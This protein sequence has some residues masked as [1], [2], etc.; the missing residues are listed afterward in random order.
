MY[1]FTL[2]IG[3]DTYGSVQEFACGR[4]PTFHGYS[5][6]KNGKFLN[7][8]TPDLANTDQE[9]IQMAKHLELRSQYHPAEKLNLNDEGYAES[10]ENLW[11]FEEQ[12]YDREADELEQWESR[13]PNNRRLP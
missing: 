11:Q 1:N 12:R 7:L 10:G 8:I 3:A 9:A 6:F 2:T 5:I 4:I 13:R